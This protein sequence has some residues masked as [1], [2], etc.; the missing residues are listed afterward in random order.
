MNVTRRQALTTLGFGA[1]SVASARPGIASQT[2]AMAPAPPT[3]PYSLPALAYPFAALE[4][5]IDSMTMQIH[6]DRD[7][8]SVV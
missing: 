4:P 5:H 7:R 6:H 8:Q 2:P 3:G 1:L